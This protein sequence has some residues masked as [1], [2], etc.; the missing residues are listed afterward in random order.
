MELAVVA[1]PAS[2]HPNDDVGDGIE[3]L[4]AAVAGGDDAVVP[5]RDPP[6]LVEGGRDLDHRRWVEGV[7]EELLGAAPGDLHW[8]A[9]DLGEARRLDRLQAGALAAEAAANVGRDHPDLLGRHP[10]LGGDPIPGRER[11]LGRGPHRHDAVLE[12]GDGGVRLHRRVGH[13]ALAERRGVDTRCGGFGGGDVAL[14]AHH[15][16]RARGLDQVL[17]YG[18][19]VER[20][21]RLLPRGV[22]QGQRLRRRLGVGVE[23]GDEAVLVEDDR[24]GHLG[25]RGHVKLA[26][27]GAVHRRAQEARVEHAGP[28]DVAGVLRGPGDLGDRVEALGGAAHHGEL[29]DLAQHRDVVD[30]AQDPPPLG[31]L[32]EGDPPGAIAGHRNHAVHNGEGSAL[33]AELLGREA[34][35]HGARLGRGGA[36]GG[37]KHARRQRPERAHVVRAAIGVAHDHVDRLEGDAQLLGDHL[38][39]RGHHPLPHLDLAGEDGDPPVLA[40]PEIRVEVLRVDPAALLAEEGRWAEGDHDHHATAH[41]LDELAPVDAGPRGHEAPP[42]SPATASMAATIRW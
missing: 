23:N 6:G 14:A 3:H 16:T 28:A 27:R 41:G 17:E 37:A 36:Q 12:L 22:R 19:V 1:A 29:G 42:S 33:H 25:R 39:L 9:H 32:A 2:R 20:R 30:G 31:E 5:E 18:L 40:D 34:Q 13:V 38:G 24:A 15:L 21:A 35:H 4:G 8:F 7:V 11:R 10:Q 26:E